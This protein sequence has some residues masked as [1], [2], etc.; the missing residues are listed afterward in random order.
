MDEASNRAAHAL[1][2]LGVGSG[3]RVAT[4]LDN[5]A[6]QVIT[7]YAA[8]KL[9]AIQVP[10]NTAYKGS[11]LLQVDAPGGTG[12]ISYTGGEEDAEMQGS[13]DSVTVEEDGR[14]TV[15]GSWDGGEAYT[16]TG[17]CAGS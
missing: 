12:T 7:F 3:D 13:V 15:E 8:I 9:G 10:I 17:S 2:G 11:F 14:F 5:S 6:E 4:L 16:L 1:A